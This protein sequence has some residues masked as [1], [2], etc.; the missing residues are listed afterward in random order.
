M[1]LNKKAVI[2]IVACVLLAVVAWIGI[3]REF[4]A[5]SYTSAILNQHFKGE[6]KNAAS[7]IEDMSEEELQKQYE[8]GVI[9]FVENNLIHGVEMDDELKAKY[10]S[11]CKEIFAKMKYEVGEAEKISRE[12]YKVPVTFNSSDAFMKYIA[13]VEDVTKGLQDKVEKGE[14]KGKEDE[15]NAQLRKEFLEG[16]YDALVKACEEQEYSESETM[17]FTVKKGE[18]GLFGLNEAEITDFLM[19]IMRLDE[20][21]D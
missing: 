21:Q 17:I 7:M 4:D 1:K 2:S 10:I 19:K 14:Y 18:N 6:V 5:A 12:E 9:S 3:F 20:I 8:D 16:S 15:I 11:V 13:F